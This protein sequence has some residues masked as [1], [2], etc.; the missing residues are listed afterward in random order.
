MRCL[1]QYSSRNSG[2]FIEILYESK[3]YMNSKELLFKDFAKAF[4]EQCK[5][6][7]A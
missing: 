6:S 2:M 1:K 3:F 5:T 4:Q 7:D